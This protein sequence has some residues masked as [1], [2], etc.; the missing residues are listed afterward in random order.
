[1]PSATIRLFLVHGDAQRLRT[2]ELSN[3]TG[4]AVAGPRS[5]LDG[6]LARDEAAKSGVYLLTG[7]DPE[8]GKRAVYIGEAESI[9]DRLRGHLDKDFWNH[10]VFFVTKDENLTKAHVRYLEGRLIEQAK[11]AGRV[12]VINSQASGSRLP[13]S[14]REDMEIFLERIHQLMPVLGDDALVP[15]GATAVGQTAKHILTCEIKGLKATGHLTPTGFVV[16]K[17]SQAVLKERSSAQQYPHAIAPRRRLIEEGALVE[18]G[19][20]FTFTRDTEFTSPS[21]AATVVHGGSTNGL[22]AWKTKEGKTLKELEA[23]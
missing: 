18:D 21:A 12:Q 6:V 17:D 10:A 11:A 19:G 22:L 1:M 13:E 2:A 9:R 23:V 3:W 20:H 16:L 4:K 7:T 8:S 14:D 15:I 5:E